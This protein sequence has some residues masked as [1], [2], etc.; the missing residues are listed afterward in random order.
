MHYSVTFALARAVGWSE[1]DALIIAGANQGM[2]ENKETV[3]DLE[4]SPI[5]TPP[6][7]EVS[8]DRLQVAGS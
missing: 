6:I 7:H 1:D 3:A 2:D 5:N 4:M 8:S